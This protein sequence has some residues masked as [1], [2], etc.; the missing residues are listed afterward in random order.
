MSRTK[1][2][3]KLSRASKAASIPTEDVEHV[4]AYWR[5]IM[6]KGTRAQLSPERKELIGSAIHD[7]TLETCLEVIRGCSLSAFHMGG[8]KQRKRYDSLDLIFRNSDK[9]EGFLQIAEDNPFVE[10]F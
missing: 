2:E 4:F 3:T 1:Q 8:N 5:E 10:P 7:Y 6:N 9:I